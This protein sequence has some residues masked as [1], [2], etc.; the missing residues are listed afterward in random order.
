MPLVPP[1]YLGLLAEDAVPT[2]SIVTRFGPI[3]FWCPSA[4]AVDRARKL[5]TKEADT[6]AWIDSLPSQGTFWDVGANIGTY[7][8]Y[9]A[10]KGLQVTTFEPSPSNVCVLA[11]SAD[12][13]G[14]GLAPICCAVAATNGIGSMR[15]ASLAFGNADIGDRE[16]FVPHF[17]MDDLRDILRLG[18]PDYIKV[19]ID[20]AEVAMIQGGRETLRKATQVHIE[21]RPET[22][23]ET[24]DEMRKLGFKMAGTTTGKR[25]Q[26]LL[27]VRTA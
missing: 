26:N 17:R 7:A 23:P 21:V 9:A 1:S 15:T 5:L 13:N 27:F 3:L 22:F 16:Y 4:K 14:L 2:I 12:I 24:V 19:D 6:T 18:Q 10:K 25:V 8:L 20:G 11:R